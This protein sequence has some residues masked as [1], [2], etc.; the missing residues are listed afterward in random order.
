VTWGPLKI[1]TKEQWRILLRINEKLEKVIS[2]FRRGNENQRKNSYIEAVL[3]KTRVIKDKKVWND[4]DKQDLETVAKIY[5]RIY[6]MPDSKIINQMFKMKFQEGMS[7]REMSKR[8]GVP[9]TTIK[10]RLDTVYK[11]IRETTKVFV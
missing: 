11:D 3:Y 2:R 8:I 6:E 5:E 10:Y 7:L 4:S 9:V 1:R